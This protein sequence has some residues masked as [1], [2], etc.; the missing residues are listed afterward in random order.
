[1]ANIDNVLGFSRSRSRARRK[2]GLSGIKGA[3]DKNHTKQDIVKAVAKATGITPAV[4]K[5]AV[6]EV[7]DYIKSH[8]GLDK[9]WANEGVTIS[10][11]GSFR[12]KIY[13]YSLKHPKTGKHYEGIKE[14][15][16]FNP[17]K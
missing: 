2:G 9:G 7:F 16:D 11:F 4:A 3:G 14:K 10:G 17:S 15:L 5:T 8:V 13:T 6:N 12:K 1:M